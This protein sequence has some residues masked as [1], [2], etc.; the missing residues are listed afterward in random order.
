MIAPD[1]P[2]F[3]ESDILP[4]A[5]FSA[6]GDAIC[7][8]LDH[9]GVGSRYIYL[10]DW[11]AP[12]GLHVAMR[13][14][15][16]VLGLIIQ[17][18]NAHRT[19]LSPQWEPVFAYSSEPTAENEAKATAH[20][21]FEGTRGTYIS[22]VPSEVTARMSP[23]CWEED[24]RV[25]QLP[26]R[27]EKERALI[28]DYGRYVTRFDAVADYLK[29]FQPPALLVWGRHDPF[30][31]LAEVLSWMRDLPRM[32]AHILDAGHMLLETHAAEAASLML[33]FITRAQKIVR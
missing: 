18:G 32:E 10:H 9:L 1:L 24:W 22:G 2:G 13:S 25:M 11:G 12:V 7:E 21:N 26:G 8:L 23:E 20:L 6:Y 29:H 30:F 16:R 5:S 15:E 27:M 19:G 3:G 31:E 14:P 28:A 4:T 17:N 33:D